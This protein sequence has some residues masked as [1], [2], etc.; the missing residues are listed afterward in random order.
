MN[1]MNG[2]PQKQFKNNIIY[3]MKKIFCLIV[4]LGISLTLFGQKKDKLPIPIGEELAKINADL[5]S[6]LK[7]AYHLYLSEKIN[8]WA[9]DDYMERGIYPPAK[10]SYVM[11]E[12]SLAKVL[13]V[14]DNDLCVYE[15]RY[16]LAS[17]TTDYLTERRALSETEKQFCDRQVR[18]MG[19]LTES[20]MQV[21]AYPEDQASFNIDVIR[22]NDSITRIYL[23][24]G[25]LA[26]NLIPFGNDF[27]FDFDNNDSLIASREY[28]HSY[29]PIS[30]ENSQT[31]EHV[32]HSHTKDNP[33]IT[34][35]DICT[36]V[37]YGYELYGIQNLSVYSSALHQYFL[38]NPKDWNCLKLKKVDS[39]RDNNDTTEKTLF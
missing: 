5:D 34:P 16:H 2:F 11:F 22:I 24:L 19:K 10:G 8:W 1:K 35:T 20:G 28:H 23:I 13:F 36:F 9:S 15:E 25:A 37:L 31:I 14:A 38:F 33:Y 29:I 12:D 26:N 32:T 6:I 4:I 18:L 30:W 3:I 17:K 27:S 7:E 21:Y 39:K